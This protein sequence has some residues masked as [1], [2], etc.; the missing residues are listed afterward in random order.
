[1]LAAPSQGPTKKDVSM[2]KMTAAVLALMMVAAGCNPGAGEPEAAVGATLTC[3][4]DQS[5]PTMRTFLVAGQSNMG[6]N[7][8]SPGTLPAAERV[9]GCAF[10]R[11]STISLERPGTEP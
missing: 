1:M 3:P 7:G 5:D 11:R 10:P 2:R 8:G 6:A 4:W 9:S